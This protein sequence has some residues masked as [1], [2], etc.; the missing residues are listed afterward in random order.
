VLGSVYGRLVE[1][2]KRQRLPVGGA[3]AH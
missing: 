1:R 2:E 3:P